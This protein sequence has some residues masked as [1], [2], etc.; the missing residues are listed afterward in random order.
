MK[1]GDPTR[2]TTEREENHERRATTN[3]RITGNRHQTPDTRHQQK[4]EGNPPRIH[5]LRLISQRGENIILPL[6][7]EFVTN[8]TKEK[9]HLTFPPQAGGN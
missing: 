5:E 6:F 9:Y 2:I 3:S 4:K 7:H 1:K 8:F